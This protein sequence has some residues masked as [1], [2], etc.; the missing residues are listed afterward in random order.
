MN[1]L[2]LT[3]N[4]ARA[5]FRLRI[6]VYLDTLRAGGINCEIAKLPSSSLARRKLF[7]QAVTFDGVFLHKKRL[8]PFDALW[9]R[10]Y[11]KSIIYDF[12]DAVMYSDKKSERVSRKRLRDFARTIKLVD[13]VIAGNRYL[14]E[15]AMQYNKNVTVLPT[16]LKLDDYSINV[17]SVEDRKIRLVW[18][19]SRSTIVYLME[20]RPVLEELGKRFDNVVLRIICD[21]F[22][23]LQNMKV[24]KCQWSLETQGKDLVTGDIGLAPLPDDR[25]TRGKCGF[26]ILQCQ[27]ASLPVVASPVG[28]AAE[29]VADGVTGYHA[30]NSQQWIDRLSKLI[31]NADLRERMGWAGKARVQQFDLRVIGK[32]LSELLKRCVEVVG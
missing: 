26:K 24:E 32:Q 27:A 21:C 19:G 2:V 11:A 20:L 13:M 28:V 12:D 16:G 31:E 1:L 5:S 10:R 17:D 7:K 8:N 4:P 14:A 22:F 15:H 30:E 9:L 3:N 25:F 6:R 23:D 29:Y 18:V